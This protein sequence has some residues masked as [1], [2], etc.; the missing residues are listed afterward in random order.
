MIQ[1][2]NGKVYSVE[3]TDKDHRIKENKIDIDQVPK[4]L[5]C[6]SLYELIRVQ[7]VSKTQDSSISLKEFEDDIISLADRMNDKF[8]IHPL[9][10][11]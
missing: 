3:D 9:L 2:I 7:L 8:N 4:L 1:M 5:D 10:M 6:F 11:Q